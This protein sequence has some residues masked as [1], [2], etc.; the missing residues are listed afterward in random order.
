MKKK[1]KIKLLTEVMSHIGFLLNQLG[2]EKIHVI[3]SLN[4]SKIWSLCSVGHIGYEIL[5]HDWAVQ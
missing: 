5:Q 1:A 2:Y 3:S 4:Q